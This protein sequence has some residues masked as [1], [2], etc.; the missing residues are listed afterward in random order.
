MFDTQASKPTIGRAQYGQISSLIAAPE[1]VALLLSAAN[2]R[3]AGQGVPSR[4]TGTN[5]AQ[6]PARRDR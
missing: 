5:A 2:K 3:C 6:Q 4:L 1:L